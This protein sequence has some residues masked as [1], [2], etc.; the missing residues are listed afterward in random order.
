VGRAHQLWVV[1]GVLGMVVM[2][3]FVWALFGI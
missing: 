2:L 1:G 3:G